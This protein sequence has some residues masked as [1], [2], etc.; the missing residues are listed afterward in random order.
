MSGLTRRHT[1]ALLIA[2]VT[3][4]ALPVSVA[5]EERLPRYPELAPKIAFWRD[6]FTKHT[7]RQLVFHDPVLLD[8]VWEVHDVSSLVDGDKSDAQKARALRDYQA[9]ATEF[10]AERIRRLERAAP[11]TDGERRVAAVLAKHAGKLP[12]HRELAA[13]IRVQRGLGDKL[14]ESYRRASAYLPQMG[15]LFTKHGVP[16][17]LAYLPLVESGYNIGAHSHKGAVGIY[18]FTRS[19]GRRYLHID[20]AVDERRDP[21]LATEAAAKY[22]RSNYDQL[23]SW[24][25]AITAYNHGEHGMAYAVRKLG[26]K[27]LPTI[28]AKYDGR[29][30]GFASKNFYAEFLAAVDSMAIARSRCGTDGMPRIERDA[31]QVTA[32]VPLRK[33]ASAAGMDI[34]ALADMNPALSSEV[35]RGRLHVPRGYTLYLPAGKGQ[36]F[37]AAYASLP[38]SAKSRE[39]ASLYGTHTVRAGETLSEIAGEYRTS[40]S[41]LLRVNGLKDPRRLRIGQRLKVPTAGGSADVVTASAES[42]ARHG[43]GAAASSVR[44]E[45]GQTLSHIAARYGVSVA[46]LMKVNGISNPTTVR[47]GQSLKIPPRGASAGVRTHRVS[48]GQTLSHIADLYRT[49]VGSLQQHNGI[50][51]PSKLRYGQVIEVP[52]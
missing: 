17:E 34:A 50:D 47:A 11:E 48:R 32:Y 41:A 21:L 14:C 39:Q 29:L 27:D 12:S 36:A 13:R 52:M 24:P 4:V 46:D 40:V 15:A 20:N 43:G 51:D 45:R 16:E 9:K 26:T 38:S 31:V 33:L 23:G 19:T 10:L 8:V 22:L 6:V 44:V 30:F 3:L 42:A 28:I 49:S 5:A 37:A 7:S 18:Q 35:V 1:V 2:L 25:L